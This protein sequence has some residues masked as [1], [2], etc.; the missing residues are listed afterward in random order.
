MLLVGHWLAQLILTNNIQ[1]RNM[2]FIGG[3][4]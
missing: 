2:T 4:A 1:M 3:Q